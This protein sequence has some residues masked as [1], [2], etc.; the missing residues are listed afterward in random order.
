MQHLPVLPPAQRLE[1]RKLA[2]LAIVLGTIEIA[3]AIA[4]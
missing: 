2:A 4:P 1:V 3:F